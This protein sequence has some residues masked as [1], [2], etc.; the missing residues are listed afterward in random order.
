MTQAIAT[1][2][3]TKKNKTKKMTRALAT[4]FYTNIK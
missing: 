2:L 1:T 3:F 4:A